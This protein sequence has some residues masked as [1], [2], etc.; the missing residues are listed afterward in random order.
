MHDNLELSNVDYVSS[1]AKSTLFGAVLYVFED[2]EA[3]IEMMI[4]GRSP[5]MRRV[6]RIYRVALDWLFHRINLDS[7][8]PPNINSQTR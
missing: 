7:K 8:I 2:N 1:N 4:K 5:T 6:S 3:V